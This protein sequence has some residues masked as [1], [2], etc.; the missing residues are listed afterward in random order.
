LP[1]HAECPCDYSLISKIWWEKKREEIRLLAEELIKL[2]GEREE[3][4]AKHWAKLA[5]RCTL[6]QENNHMLSSLERV[7]ARKAEISAALDEAE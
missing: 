3:E 2:Q 1:I 4:L 6:F 7:G 5:K